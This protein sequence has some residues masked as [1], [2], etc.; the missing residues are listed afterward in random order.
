[1]A[2]RVRA[3]RQPGACGKCGRGTTVLFA[4]HARMTEGCAVGFEEGLR[5]SKDHT[6]L[7]SGLPVHGARASSDACGSRGS[8]LASARKGRQKANVGEELRRPS[9]RSRIRR[10]AVGARTSSVCRSRKVVIRAQRSAPSAVNRSKA[11]HGKRRVD[12]GL[13]T[14]GLTLERESER[15]PKR[16]SVE[17]RTRRKE[18]DSFGRRQSSS[19]ERRSSTEDL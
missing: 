16:A 13:A 3:V 10:P 17:G 18:D 4:R 6:N 7:H 14:S 9:P 12:G 15:D 1:L 5:W 11:W 8:S 2:H 19:R